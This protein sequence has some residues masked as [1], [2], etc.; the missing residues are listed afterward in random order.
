MRLAAAPLLVV[1]AATA[2][3][4][5]RSESLAQLVTDNCVRTQR[6]V[7]RACDFS[8]FDG[9][10]RRDVAWSRRSGVSTKVSALTIRLARTGH[11][12]VVDLTPWPWAAGFYARDVDGDRDRDLVVTNGRNQAVA[13]FLNDGLGRFAFGAHEALPESAET[14]T[15][16]GF[17]GQ[18]QHRTS[19]QP[20]EAP[21]PALAAAASETA[22]VR[23]PP[24][25]RLARS[26][27]RF[28]VPTARRIARRPRAP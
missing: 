26:G 19:V 1:F 8:D 5:Q 22:S 10:Y 7:G 24:L 21:A 12:Q 17:A 18:T 28:A 13:V 2:F 23:T 3:G 4:A 9:D 14:G 25:S 20:V 11:E 15:E 16:P 27:R 6:H